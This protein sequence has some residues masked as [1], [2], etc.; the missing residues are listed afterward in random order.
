MRSPTN[1]I[2][3]NLKHNNTFQTLAQTMRPPFLVL[4]PI[5]ILLGIAVTTTISNSAIAWQQVAIIILGGLLARDLGTKISQKTQLL[6]FN[7]LV[8]LSAPLLLAISL[9][10]K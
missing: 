4:T 9:F 8:S 1:H 2:E 7:V 3:N 6:A 10:M 5:C